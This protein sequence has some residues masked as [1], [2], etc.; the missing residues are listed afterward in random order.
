[1]STEQQL[2]YEC[3]RK[4]ADKQVSNSEWINIW[5]DGIQLNRG[6]TVR[7]LGSFISEDG[8][9]SD[10]QILQNQSFTIEHTPYI[11]VDTVRFEDTS[12]GTPTHPAQYQLRFGDIASPALST[13]A[14][15]IEPP[16]H[17][18]NGTPREQTDTHKFAIQLREPVGTG[19]MDWYSSV[20][21]YEMYE[22]AYGNDAS[23]TSGVF[24]SGGYDFAI[25]DKAVKIGCY[26][27]TNSGD[28][29]A[30]TSITT[31]AP[32][33]TYL[34]PTPTAKTLSDFTL[35]NLEHQYHV[36]HICKLI[37][38]PV[39]Q[40]LYVDDVSGTTSNKR[41]T[42]NFKDDDLLQVG[43]YIST[44]YI[45]E[46]ADHSNAGYDYDPGTTFG[47][48]QWNSGPR[49]ICGKILA[50][51][52]KFVQVP[53]PITQR[54]VSMELQ[55]VYVY[56]FVNPGNYKNKNDL[57]NRPRHGS[58]QRTNGYNT[59]RNDNRN[60]G[61]SYQAYPLNSN[62]V[63]SSGPTNAILYPFYN[64][65]LP[66]NYEVQRVGQEVYGQGS[67]P[68]KVTQNINESMNLETNTSLSFFWSCRATDM[69][70]LAPDS[71]SISTGKQTH[72]TSWIYPETTLG[73][74]IPITFLSDFSLGVTQVD[75]YNTV[76]KI[77]PESELVFPGH[78]NVRIKEIYQFPGYLRLELYAG[79]PVA[80]L[81]NSALTYLPN[82]GGI[83]WYPR[84][85]SVLIED[86]EKNTG[87]NQRFWAY[88]RTLLTQYN[89]WGAICKMNPENDNVQT[90][91]PGEGF[92]H[93]L[94][95][96]FTQQISGSEYKARNFG[97]GD[98][99]SIVDSVSDPGVGNGK[100]TPVI[101]GAANYA[102]QPNGNPNTVG[103]GRLRQNFGISCGRGTPGNNINTAIGSVPVPYVLTGDAPHRI[104]TYGWDHHFEGE[105]AEYL[106]Q[107]SGNSYNDSVCSIHFQRPLDGSQE[108]KQTITTGTEQQR[109]DSINAK[110]WQ[111]DLLYVKKYKTEFKPKP[112]YYNYQ[113]VAEDI[114]IQLHY[115]FQDYQKNV[116]TNTT[117]GLRQRAKG[118]SP[119]VIN[120]N[121]VH[122]YL[123]EVSYGFMPLTKNLYEQDTTKWNINGITNYRTSFVDSYLGSAIP[124]NDVA[125]VIANPGDINIYF[126]P[127]NRTS[128]NVA[129]PD[130][131][132]L[133]LFKLN[134]A[135][136]IP[137]TNTLSMDHQD[138]QAMLTNN[139]VDILNTMQYI[140]GDT[141]F[142]KPYIAGVNYQTRT[143]FNNFK[144]G[145]CAK[146]F[147]GAVNPS[148]EID[149]DI[150]RMIFKFL[151]TPY[152]PATDDTGTALTLV[153]GQAV[154]S[155][156]IDSFGNG[157]IT[158][159]LSGIYI[160][161][162][163]AAQ[164]TEAYTPIDFL[165][166]KT[167]DDYPIVDSSY[168]KDSTSL[169]N[170]LGF[171]ENQL[172]SFSNN[173]ADLPFTFWDRSFILNNILY[174]I[175]E[176]DISVNASNPFYSYC[177]LV[178]P[179]L[180]FSVEVD[181]NEIVANRQPLTQNSPFYLIGSD[182]PGK[183]YYGNK[184]TK[185]PVMGVCSRQFTSFGFAFDLSESA[186]QWTIE[187][188]VF[189]TSIHTKIYNNDMSIPLNLDDN[190]SIIYAITKAQYYKQPS[191]EDLQNTEQLMLENTIP[192]IVYTP[193]TFE[194]PNQINY[195]AP[196]FYDEDSD[197]DE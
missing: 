157:G 74:A 128:D 47:D 137:T 19:F 22:K 4:T 188:D 191:Q 3:S 28:P 147:V 164:I 21:W 179:N 138:P 160:R 88:E 25:N 174:N 118:V 111:E 49:S 131:K 78:P 33:S 13:D 29:L 132:S 37:Y 178:L 62:S 96:P 150:Q 163:R 48:I 123:P 141:G 89:N 12:S 173:S 187:E 82:T 105:G 195:E 42:H 133:Q 11:N 106:N 41:I 40:G 142:M 161:N 27:D 126:V 6:D 117:V 86:F 186:I 72:A 97:Q 7:L 87:A 124:T 39:F 151:Y 58:S 122:T 32:A 172:T 2:I 183:H 102:N 140:G 127:F 10:I 108:F 45:A 193:Q 46:A 100:N 152:R 44:Y 83:Y 168:V 153:S 79:I 159:S 9:S 15:G 65:Y 197:Y 130:D 91:I 31:G 35:L 119:N 94:Y 70:P 85:Y 23:N 43:D 148:F 71:P 5:R 154:P 170:T 158:D 90:Y 139:S 69:R 98:S 1:M 63:V 59:N 136:L 189:I 182:F 190:S 129:I 57:I 36:A 125:N 51:N 80:V 34:V 103:T 93:R 175:A 121:F 143:A 185:L 17:I 166:F 145:G 81:K 155:A 177:S 176:T 61:V 109:V 112:G 16:Y 66:K 192:P 92:S 135:K 165:G 162:L 180:Q 104:S 194:Y 18:L 95:I 169:W 53:D 120:G 84:Q 114:N 149:L 20:G 8:D 55:G 144:Y 110:L 64:S 60:A 30:P 56:E 181:S 146:I 68:L 167:S 54:T 184:G 75:I 116:G 24:Y 196:L 52:K 156:I 14:Y 77:R 101:G 73:S 115:N 50:T 99:F 171:S 67:S 26:F 76:N 113:Q 107:D 134:G 38:F